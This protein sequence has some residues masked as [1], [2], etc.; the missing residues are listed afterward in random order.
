M[1]IYCCA[2]NYK[3]FIKLVDYLQFQLKYNNYLL[4]L[5]V[6]SCNTSYVLISD[7]HTRDTKYKNWHR[8][9]TGYIGIN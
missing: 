5:I 6:N 7:L 3:N 9:K 2:T 8:K 1:I 4:F